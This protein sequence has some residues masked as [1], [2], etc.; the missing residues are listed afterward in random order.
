MGKAFRGQSIDTV[1]VLIIF[2]I[3]AASVLAVLMLGGSIYKNMADISQ[4]GY[5]ERTCLS[6]VWTKV[7]NGDEAGK[8]LLGDFDGQNVLLLKEEY[9]G[10]AYQT[11]IYYYDG[12]VREL[13]CEE[14]L[15]FAPEDGT[16]VIKTTSLSFTALENGL[17][18]A[19]AGSGSLLISPR[20]SAGAV[21]R[22]QAGGT[23]DSTMEIVDMSIID[24][25]ADM[26]ADTD[27]ASTDDLEIV[28]FAEGGLPL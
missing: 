8:I 27:A 6:Y 9:D 22:A 4:D 1:F 14:G 21:A 12:W 13:F 23:M 26:G 25:G 11:M 16:P 7:K 5:E 28:E 19:E 20:G 3:F 15:N 18:K 10:V 24:L 2:C 17:I